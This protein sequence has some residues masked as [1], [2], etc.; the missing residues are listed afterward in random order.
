MIEYDDESKKI[1]N[2]KQ[3]NHSYKIKFKNKQTSD[4]FIFEFNWLLSIFINLFPVEIS[5]SLVDIDSNSSSFTS[6]WIVNDSFVF[7]HSG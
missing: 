5:S 1:S 6:F 4:S 2:T 3:P 7:E